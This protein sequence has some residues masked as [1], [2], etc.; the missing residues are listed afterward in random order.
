MVDGEQYCGF[1]PEGYCLRQHLARVWVI[2][3]QA[4]GK[5]ATDNRVSIQV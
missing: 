1:G 3:D 5:G 4:V 2:G